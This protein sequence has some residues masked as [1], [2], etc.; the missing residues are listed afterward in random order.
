MKKLIIFPDIHGR[1]FWKEAFE[2][3]KDNEDFG[4]IFLGD[5]LDAYGFEGISNVDAIKNFEDILSNCI[6]HPRTIMLL[7][8][9][10]IH[11]LPPLDKEWGCRRYDFDKDYIQKLFLDNLEKFKVCHIEKI[12]ETRYLF[13]HA[14]FIQWWVK[15]ASALINS[16]ITLENAN[17]LIFT[18]NGLIA[19][20]M[21][22]YE[23]G[24][25]SRA[26][27]GSCV[28][29][30]INEHFYVKRFE[31]DIYQ[32]FAHNQTFPNYE[33]LTQYYIDEDFAMLDSQKPFVLDLENG[34]L[35]E[36]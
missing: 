8:N 34:K 36:L 3:Y 28:W 19:L 5:Y 27:V 20:S 4:F 11:Y 12:G 30:D 23:R 2:K 33:D 16:E 1:K 13:S 22:G 14:G 32:I 6:D 15:Q 10:D 24:A 9:H 31:P 35:K 25:R 17:D 18:E 26:A 21:Y 7:G 29:A